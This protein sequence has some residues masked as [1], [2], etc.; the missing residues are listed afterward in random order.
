MTTGPTITAITLGVR[1]VE[2]ARDF[3]VDGLGFRL[4]LDLP[5][6]IAFVQCAPGQLLALWD[7]AQMP[8][9]YGAVAHGPDGAAAVARPQRDVAAVRSSSCMPPR[10]LPAPPPSLPRRSGSGEASA[11]AWPTSTASAGTSCS[12]PGFRVDADGTVHLGAA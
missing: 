3:Y 12:N 2:A 6:E 1:D 9:E 11:P 10:W 4:V 5:D 7:V 8:S